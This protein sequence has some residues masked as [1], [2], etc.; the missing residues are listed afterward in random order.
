MEWDLK[1]WQR[2]ELWKK[3]LHSLMSVAKKVILLNEAA[4]TE[5]YTPSLS[6]ARP[7]S[8]VVSP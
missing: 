5:F 1:Q 2:F 4:T 7:I 8:W 3:L 6:D